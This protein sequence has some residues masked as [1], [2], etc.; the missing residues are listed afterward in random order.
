MRILVLAPYFAPAI[1]AGGPAITMTNLV[2]ELVRDGLV[3]D[4]V[5]PD[6][7]LGDSVAFPGLS[8]RTVRRGSATVYYLD[9]GS[10]RQ[11]FSLLRRLSRIR[12]D[13]IVLNSIWRLR[14]SFFPAILVALRYLK[15]PVLLLPRGELEGGALALKSRKKSSAGPVVRGVYGRSVS[16]FGATSHQEAE[17]IASWFPGRPVVI[18]L[19][20]VPDSI[21]W[22]Q[23]STPSRHLRLLY[24]ARIHPTKGLLPLLRGLCLTTREVE[25]SIVGPLEDLEYWSKCE[26]V[27]GQLPP[28]ATVKK[29]GLARRD[30]IPELLWNADCMVLLTAG[31]NYGHV[32]AESLQAGCSVIATPTTPWTGVL[33]GG[34]GEIVETRDDAQTVGQVLDRWA[35]KSPQELLKARHQARAAYEEFASQAGPNIVEMALERL[36]Q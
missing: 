6:R 12:Y 21:Q 7:D 33:R 10:P 26:E 17:S 31:E 3:V 30:E 29:V 18:S 1:R 8:G 14:L 4:V 11:I 2:A 19:N 20:N 32:I 5:A 34:G 35:A 22:G 23:P 15:G 9:E 27:L 13:L 36:R 16:V 25:L 28:N 24:L